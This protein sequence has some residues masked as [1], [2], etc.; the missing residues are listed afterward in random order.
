MDSGNGAMKAKARN[1][2]KMPGGG[3]DYPYACDYTSCVE[4]RTGL[5]LELGSKKR[6]LKKPK[7]LS[8]S[9]ANAKNEISYLCSVLTLALGQCVTGVA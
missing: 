5:Q 8:E 7:R 3:R 1:I 4:G 2:D 9:R 6:E